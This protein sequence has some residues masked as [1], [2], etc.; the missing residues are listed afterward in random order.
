MSILDIKTIG[1]VQE[2]NPQRSCRFGRLQIDQENHPR[3]DIWI[4]VTE[5]EN[6]VQS[7]R[8]WKPEEYA[9]ALT[10]YRLTANQINNYIEIERRAVIERAAHYS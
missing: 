3:D 10:D 8:L 7:V 1:W 9:L 5:Y 6:S 4:I 2:L